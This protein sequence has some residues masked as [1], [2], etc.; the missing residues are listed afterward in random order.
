[1][2]D[3]GVIFDSKLTFNHHVCHLFSSCVRLLDFI[4]RNYSTLQLA[5]QKQA[6][7]LFSHLEFSSTE[8][9]SEIGKTSKEDGE[10]PLLQKFDS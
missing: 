2:R 1:M 7:I 3:L 4:L 8:S 9:D 10:K 5:H 6:R